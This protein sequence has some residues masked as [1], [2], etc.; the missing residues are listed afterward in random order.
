MPGQPE[1]VGMA[2]GMGGMAAGGGFQE[3]RLGGAA[4]GGQFHAASSLQ[5]QM[6]EQGYGPPR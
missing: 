5:M 2:A 6:G 4:A 1:G 3:Q